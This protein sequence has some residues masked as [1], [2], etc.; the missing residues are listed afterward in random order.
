ML[1]LG[2]VLGC[3]MVHFWPF[4]VFPILAAIGNRSDIVQKE[5]IYFV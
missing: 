4:F 2:V 5:P 3:Y 1:K